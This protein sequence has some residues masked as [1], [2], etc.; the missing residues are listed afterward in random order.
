VGRARISDAP[1]IVSNVAGNSLRLLTEQ[2]P[3][4]RVLS[5]CN[6]FEFPWAK[7]KA[8]GKLVIASPHLPVAGTPKQKK[9]PSSSPAPD[10]YFLFKGYQF[11]Q[12]EWDMRRE[13]ILPSE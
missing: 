1:A 11:R 4:S 7:F 9:G 6:R 8:T 2:A 12:G 10:I 13:S 5:S 3:E